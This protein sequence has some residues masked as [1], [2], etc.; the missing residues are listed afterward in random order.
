VEP[1]GKVR[2]LRTF[3]DDEGSDRPEAKE[4]LGRWQK[5][6]F[7]RLKSNSD[8]ERELEAAEVSRER[9]IAEFEELRRN[10]NIIRNGRFAGRLL[11]EILEADFKEYNEQAA[12]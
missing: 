1:G 6:I 11:V 4:A 5:E 2:Q 9:R 12:V 10:G 3:G 8:G 7:K